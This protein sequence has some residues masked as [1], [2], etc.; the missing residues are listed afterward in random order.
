M[1]SHL[2]SMLGFRFHEE[3]H[4]DDLG[5]CCKTFLTVIYGFPYLARVFDHGKLIPAQSYKHSSLVR[6]SINYGQKTCYNIGPQESY[7]RHFIFFVT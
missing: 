6:K 1:V 4:I 7:S 5:Q 2:P 3:K